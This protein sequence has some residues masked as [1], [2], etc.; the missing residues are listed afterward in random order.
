MKKTFLNKT[1][2]K[3][4]FPKI[5][6]LFIFINLLISSIFPDAALA[7][8][9]VLGGKIKPPP[10]VEKYNVGG[11]IGIIVFISNLIKVATVVAGIWVLINVILAGWKYITSSG[12]SKAHGEVSS[13]ITYSIIG[14]V[15]IVLAYT[16]TALI[17]LIIFG[18][19]GF[20]LNPQIEGI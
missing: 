18:D 4:T 3:K 2:Q 7:A 1:L 16:I 12:D 10:G 15:I 20:I 5:I 17:S 13:K 19:A 14:L 8:D 6:S 9:D 11:R